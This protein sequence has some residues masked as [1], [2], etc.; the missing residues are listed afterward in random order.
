[1][2]ERIEGF[3]K[4]AIPIAEDSCG[5][6]VWLDQETGAIFFWDHEI[7]GVGEKIAESFETFLTILQPFDPSSVRLRPGQV[8]SVWA[9]PDFKPE[10]D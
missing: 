1:M 8:K 2:R 6:Y 5:N 4:K 10:F 7:D 9:N 3:P